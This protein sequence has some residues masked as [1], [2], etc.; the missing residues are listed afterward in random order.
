MRSLLKNKMKIINFKQFPSFAGKCIFSI[1]SCVLFS[2]TFAQNLVKN[3]SLEEYSICPNDF[4]Q[5]QFANHW[6]AGCE[7]G[8]STDYFNACMLDDPNLFIFFKQPLTQYKPSTGNAEA[9]LLLLLKSNTT[10]TQIREVLSSKL[11]FRLIP[12]ICYDVSFKIR[13]YGYYLY[14]ININNLNYPTDRVSALLSTDSIIYPTSGFSNLFLL[15][16]QINYHGPVLNDTT[17]WVKVEGSFV[18]QGNEQ[19]IHITSFVPDDSVTVYMLPSLSSQIDSAYMPSYYL[20]DD[21]AV[22]PCDAPIYIANTGKDTCINAGNSIT[23]GTL[24]R[25]EYLYWWYDMQGNLLDTTATL[26]V[27]PAQT[28]SYV[29]VQKDFKFDKTRD[30]VIVS[31]GNC[32]L[33]DYSNLNFEIYPNPCSEQVKV[34]FNAKIPEGT[35][36]KLYDMIVI[37]QEVAQY[38]LTGTENIAT[39]NLGELATGI[40]H[41]TV[42]VPDVMKKSVKLLVIRND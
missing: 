35:V 33:P 31:V 34:R 39:V 8:V 10:T 40:Y 27:S 29:L 41:A 32:P 9:G 11:K 24:R 14:W 28:T 21:V 13:F 17:A 6:S 16:P 36:L 15:H 30:T 42:M 3:P 19:W 12:N 26:I 23:I 18:A 2:N 4:S 20:I 37:G 7:Y 38:P 22:Y 1:L 25:A 5:I